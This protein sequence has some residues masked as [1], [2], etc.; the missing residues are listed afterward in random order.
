MADAFQVD[1]E[2]HRKAQDGERPYT[3][4]GTD[5]P[6]DP[7]AAPSEETPS[8][9]A[10]TPAPADTKSPE[11]EPDENLKLDETEAEAAKK[12]VTD[13]GLDFDALQQEFLDTGNLSPESRAALVEKTGLPE[14]FVDTYL[15]G[16]KAQVREAAREAHAI[17]GGESEYKAMS[18]WAKANLSVEERKAYN[19][20]LDSGAESAKL[21][22]KGVVAQ[23][24]VSG[25]ATEPDLSGAGRARGGAE[26]GGSEGPIFSRQELAKIVQTERYQ[27]DPA[28]QRSIEKRVAA[29][30]KSG[31]YNTAS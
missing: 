22:I 16:F 28:Y 17:A 9:D 10:E 5:K 13:A 1:P 15:N 23:W 27:R 25:S 14:H 3:P 30:Q 31:R 4:P 8:A 26:G 6:T 21:A 24:K 19:A 12:V 20:A 2:E 18:K 11:A 29:A 7:P